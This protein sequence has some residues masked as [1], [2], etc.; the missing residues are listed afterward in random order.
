M[1][2][3][4]FIKGNEGFQYSINIQ[5]DLM[6]P[7]KIK[8]YIPTRKSV[9]ILKEYLLNTIID[10]RDKATVLI[11]PYGKGKS[12]LLLI[13]LGLMCGNKNINELNQLVEKISKI[14]NDCAQ[15]A[16]DVLKS[17]KYLPIVINFNSGDLNQAFL[18]AL[19]QTL[20]NN[21]IQNI[22][23][24]TYFDSAIAV[25]DGW[26]K[27]EGTINIVKNLIK[28][29]CT[30][31]L[32]TFKRKLKSFDTVSYEA[33]KSIFKEVTSGVEFNPFIN[34][35]VVKLYEETNY[36][37]KEKYNYD[38]I[39]VV[40]DEFS[41]F[42]EA[43]G[44]INSAMNLKIL[45]D[46]AEL[47]S[48]SKSPQ[49]HLVCITHKTINE[50]I[51]KI[52]QEKIDAWRAIEGRFKEVLF[53]SSSQQNYELIS[54]AIIKDVDKV[55]AELEKADI[56]NNVSISNA[57]DLFK[58]NT[59]EYTE[60]IVE[61]CFP[62]NPY[63]TYVL[64]I[65][66]EKVAQ[67]ERSLFTYLSKDEPNS[68]IDLINNNEKEF[69]FVTIDK[70]YDYFE[71]L[72][73][74]ETFNE[75]LYEIWIK[76]DTALKIVYSEEEKRLIK[77]L[78]IIYIVNDFRSLPAT[79]QVLSN[80]LC[81]DKLKFKEIIANLRNT[82]VLVLRRSSDTLDFIPISSVDVNGKIKNLL[83]TKF[84]NPN[85]TE[86]FNELVNLKYILPK[87]YNDDFKMTRFFKRTFMTID[88]LTAYKSSEK[89]LKDYG[90]DGI[91]VD[92]INVNEDDA[93]ESVRWNNEINDNRVILVIPNEILKVK[94]EIAE[95]KAISY[96]KLDEEFLKEDT[97]IESQ[98]DILLDDITQKITDYINQIYDITSNK[99]TLY[100]NGDKYSEVRQTKLSSLISNICEENF[101][102]SPV[103]N[104]EMINKKEISAQIKKARNNIVDM[105]LDDS[106]LEFDSSKTAVECTL[107][108]ATLL[109]KGFLNNDYDSDMVILLDEIK[110]FILRASEKELTFEELYEAITSNKNKIGIRKGVLPIYLAF[111]LK[112][113]KEEV[114]IYLKSGR[115]KK[116]LVLD[117]SIIDNIN[118]NPKDYLIKIEKGTD[119]KDRYITQ[120]TEIFNGYLKKNSKNKYVDIIDG[121]KSWIQS[122]S[123][124]TQNH[125]FN[126][127]TK[128]AV[129][130]EVVKLRSELVKYEINYRS[131]IFESLPKYLKS[132]SFDQCI[133]KLKKI[134]EYLD[135]HDEKVREYLISET[136]ALIDKNY[137]GTLS[138]NLRKWASELTDD[139]KA[140]LYD[141][142]TNELL[143]YI[144]K[145]DNNEIDVINKLSYIFTNLSIE[146]WNDNTISIYL[147]S[148]KNS[149][150]YVESYEVS[151]DSDNDY[152]LTKIVINGEEKTFSK[153]E[154][155]PLGST[156]FNAIEEALDEY[157]DSIDDNE[158]RNILMDILAK[159]I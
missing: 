53:N 91:I 111:V 124:F 104:N 35:D 14:D 58:Y 115:S 141:L 84:K 116:E 143:R 57:I 46:L 78:G 60:H 150:N 107:F 112:D 54:N 158:K 148:F 77:A 18:I 69:D 140:H 156:L 5:Y 55:K 100:I 117:T 19:N 152:E 101:L 39:I 137:K 43:S 33:F 131:F 145:I 114:I 27:Y 154:I 28:E 75:Y 17:K 85:L 120:L 3:A 110:K 89:L 108:R 88:Q 29:K 113:Y 103:I 38:G 7:N 63:A 94:E 12:H 31:D 81:I 70:L 142:E 26:E 106:Y 2:Y 151:I 146:D 16:E 139:Q 20:K 109:N 153:T 82:N 132:Q 13:L 134:K 123:L 118:S 119:E 52:P 92:L 138:G 25:L 99:N 72:F 41:K 42:I 126:I 66:S 23:P 1:R 4:D 24:N 98:L 9:E 6:N 48:R 80:V 147:D 22:L 45:Q 62:L 96:L 49:M 68:L 93:K 50:Y 105:I 40:F 125:K 34:T 86:S 95:Y 67:N 129:S 36:I 51:S 73:R 155:S 83:E 74:K 149:K 136:K 15:I 157:G 144:Q 122:L 71:P 59:D 79:E 61:G 21:E 127:L 32:N 159:Y 30:S 90:T 87:R 102:N 11:G 133:K 37:L 130:S 128:E 56:K 76:T 97:A 121:M 64:P 10:D 44:D 135:K 65:I 47:S 8:G